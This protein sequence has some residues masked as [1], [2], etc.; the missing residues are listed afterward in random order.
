MINN[1]KI[2]NLSADSNNAFESANKWLNEWD[3]DKNIFSLLTSGSTGKSKI[4]ELTKNQFIESAQLTLKTLG[5]GKGDKLLI[6]LNPGFIAGKMMIIRGIIG[7]MEMYFIEPCANPLIN[8]ENDTH[9]DFLSFVPL[10]I[11][12]ILTNTPEK[13]VILNKAKAIIIG[14]APINSITNELIQQI[15]A[16]VYHTYGM[17]ET[18]SHIALKKLNGSNKNDIYNTL[19]GV[20]I[21]I[22]SRNCLTIKHSIT[23][24]IEIVTNDII[25]LIAP[26]KFKWIGRID[27]IINSGGYKFSPIQIE[28]KLIKYF[29]AA[30]IH[31]RFF[32]FALP[33]TKL[34]NS[35]NIAFESVIS[36]ESIKKIKEIFKSELTN[37][38]TPKN[39]FNCDIFTETD[40]QKIDKRTTILNLK[41]IE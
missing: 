39:I 25:E 24:N 21:N 10:Q 19:E 9:F 36:S 27:D 17:T 11:E 2:I 22:D 41:L 28:D 35:I 3:S 40:S 34:G 13:I 20:E 6:N 15:K 31:N 14:G 18:V 23:N 8:I 12:T 16:P 38:E 33:N 1:H 26:N 7:Q 32:I 30:N 5:L 4:I 29:N 37:F